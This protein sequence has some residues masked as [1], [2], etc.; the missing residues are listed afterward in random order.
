MLDLQT[1]AQPFHHLHARFSGHVTLRAINDAAPF[2][3]YGPLFEAHAEPCV[4]IAEVEPGTVI[5]LEAAGVVHFLLQRLLGPDGADVRIVGPGRLGG[6]TYVTT[7]VTE[8]KVRYF[9][10]HEDALDA[11]A[12]AMRLGHAIGYDL[13]A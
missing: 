6:P 2:A 10:T 5:D 4:V 3:R 13:A 11:P 7:A 12:R 9:E 8:G 1:P